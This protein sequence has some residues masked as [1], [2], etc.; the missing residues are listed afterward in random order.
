MDAILKS[1]ELLEK[2]LPILQSLPLWARYVVSLWIITGGIIWT[3]VIVYRLVSP[4]DKSDE[5]SSQQS[6][7]STVQQQTIENSPAST[8]IQGRDIII[9]STTHP[10]ETATAREKIGRLSIP[11]SV[12]GFI[13]SAQ[14]GDTIAVK[15][16]TEAGMNVDAKEDNYGRT[17]LMEAAQAGHLDTVEALTRKKAAVNAQDELG[18]TALILAASRGHLEVVQTL[19][20][21]HAEPNI[22]NIAG[23]TALRATVENGHK[24]VVLAL[25]DKGA[26]LETRDKEE[27][28]TPLLAAAMHHQTDIVRLLLDRGADANVRDKY[29]HSSLIPA[30]RAG[31]TDMV[32]A[33]LSHGADVNAADKDGRTALMGAAGHGHTELIAL[34]LEHKADLKLVDKE[35]KTALSWA[36]RGGHDKI[37]ELLRKPAE[38]HDM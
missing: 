32:K 9:Q 27:H 10:I 20:K 29:G 24:L 26:H 7:S 19:L 33:L 36:E 18:D 13:D 15:L 14:H 8:N 37:M 2:F 1:M 25:L 12:Q 16:F 11:Y 4:Q 21:K 3:S 23:R 34:L 31:H 30:A 38:T 6:G 28:K 22:Q 35:G 17:A 5:V